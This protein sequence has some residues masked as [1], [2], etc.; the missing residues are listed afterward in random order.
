MD[1]EGKQ[2]EREDAGSAQAEAE[3]DAEGKL[4]E[5]ADA[6]R[7]EVEESASISEQ[8]EGGS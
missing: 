3:V 2:E 4:E 8:V 1:A 6:R 7:A 5:Q